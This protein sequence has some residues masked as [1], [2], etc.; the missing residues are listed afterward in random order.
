MCDK[1]SDWCEISISKK[2]INPKSPPLSLRFKGGEKEAVN[3]MTLTCII[4][5]MARFKFI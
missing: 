3:W 4:Q 5:F 2:A 1:V